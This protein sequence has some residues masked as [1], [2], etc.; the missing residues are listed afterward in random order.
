MKNVFHAQDDR[1]IWTR[2]AEGPATL[3]PPSTQHEKQGGL[4][5]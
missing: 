4:G 1:Q 3:H 5:K 2:D